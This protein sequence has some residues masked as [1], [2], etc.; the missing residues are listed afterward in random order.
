[1]GCQY[2]AWWGERGGG[3]RACITKMISSSKLCNNHSF[4]SSGAQ[5]EAGGGEGGGRISYITVDL[6]TV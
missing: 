3:Q 5:P 6:I 2:Y 4:R 1:M